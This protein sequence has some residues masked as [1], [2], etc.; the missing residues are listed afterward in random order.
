MRILSLFILMIAVTSAQA[1]DSPDPR[2]TRSIQVRESPEGTEIILSRFMPPTSEYYTVNFSDGRCRTMTKQEFNEFMNP[3]PDRRYIPLS[4]Q[5]KRIT[6]AN[7]PSRSI[8]EPI[9]DRAK[10]EE[11]K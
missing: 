6:E 1:S 8:T 3:R 7:K 10:Q 11:Q 9:D 5:L 2:T 4:E